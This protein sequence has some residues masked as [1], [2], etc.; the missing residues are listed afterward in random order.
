MPYTMDIYS[1]RH[2]AR[3]VGK[4]ELAELYAT[5][6]EPIF[7]W[8][9]GGDD[10]L[11][12][13]VHDDFSTVS[14][15]HDRTWYYLEESPATEL[16]EILL[17]GQEAWVPAGVMLDRKTGLEALLLAHNFPELLTTF[18]WREQ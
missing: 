11:I 5:V 13:S 10:V 9:D 4:D 3:V 1:P 6:D 15:L 7:T 8:N 17:C 2:E 14:M 18:R 16:V 12:V